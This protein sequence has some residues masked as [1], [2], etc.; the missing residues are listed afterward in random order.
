MSEAEVILPVAIAAIG[1]LL[2]AL[3]SGLETGFYT[4]NPVR[5]TVRS[6][7]GNAAAVALRR[8]L[9]NPYRTL[10]V[11]LIGTNAANYLAS[12]GIAEVLADVG[13]EGWTLIAVEVALVTPLIFVF[14][15]TLPKDLF[16]THTDRWTYRLSPFIILS[17]WVFTATLLLPI[18]Q[19]VS[20][21]AI[22]VFRVPIRGTVT[23]RQRI[24]QLIREGVGAG[25]VTPHQATLTDRALT[26]RD[27]RVESVMVPWTRVVWVR[28]DADRAAR[29]VLIRSRNY[30]R[31]PVVGADGR[32]IGVL[33]WADA[34]LEV[35]RA[36][37]E[38]A[39]ATIAFDPGTRLLDALATM[40]HRRCTMAV[41][42]EP[43]TDRPLGIVTLK[44]LVEPLTGELAA[45]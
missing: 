27:R 44:D 10:T 36:T 8:Q 19:A 24:S 14:A 35:D 38:L 11:L 20:V 18:V 6:A 15:E 2:S 28:A 40:R 45:W 16:R 29:E 43:G 31:L 7:A 25:V 34:V 42:A 30:T 17:R 41:V 26:L 5:L 23:A 12:Y 32:V 37:A 22:R 4:L 21:A 13:I 3:Y 9:G 1:F 39:T 33:G